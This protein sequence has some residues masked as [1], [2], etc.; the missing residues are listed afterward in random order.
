MIFCC[1]SCESHLYLTGVATAMPTWYSICNQCLDNSE[2]RKQRNGALVTHTNA[3]NRYVLL[4]RTDIARFVSNANISPQSNLHLHMVAGEIRDGWCP[5]R[6][7]PSF[8]TEIVFGH[9]LRPDIRVVILVAVKRQPCV[10]GTYYFFI[11]W[12]H[13]EIIVTFWYPISHTCL[14]QMPHSLAV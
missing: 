2:N 10:Q 14:H 3:Q 12:H 1:W 13:S 9:D 7:E 4:Q 5:V 11:L 8:I 6:D